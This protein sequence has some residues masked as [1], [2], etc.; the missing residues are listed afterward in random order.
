MAR[1]MTSKEKQRQR[2]LIIASLLLADTPEER[3]GTYKSR[4]PRKPKRAAW[5]M[6]VV[7]EKKL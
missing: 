6:P 3:H 2:D 5:S 7:N 4:G 1:E